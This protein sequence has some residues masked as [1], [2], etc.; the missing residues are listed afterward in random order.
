MTLDA[1]ATNTQLLLIVNGAASKRKSHTVAAISAGH[2]EL[3]RAAFTVKA[4][5]LICGET[6]HKLLKIPIVNES[7]SKFLAP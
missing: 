7:S 2:G 6:L 5:Y 3:A 4:A 1:V